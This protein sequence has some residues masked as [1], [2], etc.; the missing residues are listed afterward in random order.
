M[1]SLT[2]ALPS[3][4]SLYLHPVHNISEIDSL[5]ILATAHFIEA[6]VTSRGDKCLLIELLSSFGSILHTQQEWLFC[7]QLDL[8]TV[9]C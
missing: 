4:L 5:S 2:D 9:P 7:N 6:P 8:V 3:P 1:R